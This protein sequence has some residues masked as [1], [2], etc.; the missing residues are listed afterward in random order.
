VG[1]SYLW[2]GSPDE[3]ISAAAYR[4]ELEGKLA[5]H[6]LRPLIDRIAWEEEHCYK[7]YLSELMRK[8]LPEEYA[9]A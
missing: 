5:G 1:A 2:R 3:T 7:A 4:M 8:Q 9:D 6:I